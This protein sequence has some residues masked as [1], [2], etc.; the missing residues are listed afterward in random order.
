MREAL[1]TQLSQSVALALADVLTFPWWWYVSGFPAVL[2]WAGQTL[3]G[4]EHT[5][6][7]ALWA[8]HLFVPMFGQTDWQSRMI[9]VALRLAVLLGRMVQV[10]L[11]ALAVALA[12]IA[13]L[14]LPPIVI[15][16]VV[17]SAVPW[18]EW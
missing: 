14:A 1:I 16:Q 17:R 13:Y 8:K 2:R 3:R 15:V 5:V 18:V 6:G 10:V 4:W 12:V 11:G 7:F 9:S